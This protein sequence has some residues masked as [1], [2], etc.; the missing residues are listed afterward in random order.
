MI[1]VAIDPGPHTGVAVRLSDGTLDHFMIHNN[2]QEVWKY[3]V[4]LQPNV[5]IVERF[6]AGGMISSDGLRTV[7]IQGSIFSLAWMLGSQMYVQTPG[8]RK[9]FEEQ[10][11]KLIAANRT[12][13]QSHDVDAVAHL[14]RWEYMEAQHQQRQPVVQP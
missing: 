1:I 7:E 4:T 13:I 5:V 11:R 14:L 3:L 6:R 9:P 10:A 8:D 12:K 2:L